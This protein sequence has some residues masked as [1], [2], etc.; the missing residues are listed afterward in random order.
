M[1]KE[2]MGAYKRKGA[3]ES[4][5]LSEDG[6]VIDENKKTAG[7]AEYGGKKGD[8][9]KSKKDYE[10]PG[11]GKMH[12]DKKTDGPGRSSGYTQNFGPARVNG[13]ARGAA[14]VMSIMQG[15]AQQDKTSSDVDFKIDEKGGTLSKQKTSIVN[16]PSN[17]SSISVDDKGDDAFYNNL[18]SSSKDM[19]AMKTQGIDPNNKS[20][21]LAYGIKKS[22]GMNSGTSSSSV[23]TTSSQNNPV[24]TNSIA[25]SG[26]AAMA[27]IVGDM[28]LGNY[29][30]EMAS[31]QD[32][33]TAHIGTFGKLLQANTNRSAKNIAAMNTHAG[34]EGNKAANKTR[35]LAGIPL[36]K[37]KTGTYDQGLGQ[38]NVGNSNIPSIGNGKS[39]Y[40]PNKAATYERDGSLF[41]DNFAPRV[42]GSSKR[43]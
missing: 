4:K 42:L 41:M 34:I 26:N 21:V 27:S 32:S 31:L 3:A 22:K 37:R 8:D 16:T 2:K 29:N 13:Y 25:Q 33:S 35:A 18:V 6:D 30:S 9:S 40:L 39:T 15:T 38:I 23:S 14:K 10:G 12:M 5:Y 36:V 17:S 20:S 24:T 1:A 11:K 19:S 7:P 28:N 43:K